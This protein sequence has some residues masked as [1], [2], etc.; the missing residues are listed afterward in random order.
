MFRQATWLMTYSFMDHKIYSAQRKNVNNIEMV[1]M[2]YV[3]GN[4]VH[5][6]AESFHRDFQKL[7]Y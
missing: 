2:A 6:T 7:F 5:A 4:T 1:I 3:F